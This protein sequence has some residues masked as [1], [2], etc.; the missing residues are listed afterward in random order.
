[1]A[2]I[3]LGKVKS[4]DIMIKCFNCKKK[5]RSLHVQLLD[6]QMLCEKCI[7]ICALMILKE[8]LQRVGELKNGQGSKRY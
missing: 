1:M 4:T 3:N 5:T 8:R 2:K 7:D 6:D